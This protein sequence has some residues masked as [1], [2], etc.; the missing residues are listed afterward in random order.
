MSTRPNKSEP[1]GATVL[2]CPPGGTARELVR[3]GGLDPW[4]AASLVDDLFKRRF[5]WASDCGRMRFAALG[6]RHS[7][8]FH[9]LNNAVREAAEEFRLPLQD[10]MRLPLGLFV[11]GESDDR[12]GAFELGESETAS[13][14]WMP[15][16][17]LIADGDDMLLYCA[18]ASLQRELVPRLKSAANLPGL[19]VPHGS[20][21]KL[22]ESPLDGKDTWQ[23]RVDQ[24]LELIRNGGLEKLVVSRRLVFGSDHE[25]FSPAASTWQTGVAR[26]R[27]G[28]SISMDR[29]NSMFIGATPETLLRV[30]D[31][32]MTTHALAGTRE[33]N[34]TLEAF[35]A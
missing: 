24:A 10:A 34:A 21:T 20:Q 31:G 26:N 35:L 11:L 30:Q 33:R 27:T 7:V 19:L 32:T 1:V 5:L 9:D 6:E 14:C 15:Q 17:L 3:L 13:Y 28:F 23:Q 12:P 2:R 25:P 29:G 18:D 22:L 16:A 8:A 4:H